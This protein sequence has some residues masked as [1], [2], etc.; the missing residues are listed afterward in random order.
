MTYPVAEKIFERCL[1]SPL[2]PNQEIEVR[3]LLK[4]M[5]DAGWPVEEPTSAALISIVGFFYARAP[6]PIDAAL[7]TE[8]ISRELQESTAII[9]KENIKPVIHL[10]FLETFKNIFLEAMTRAISRTALVLTG[11]LL[12][13]TAYGTHLVDVRYLQNQQVTNVGIN[14][15]S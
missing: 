6:K 14:S 8:Q 3:E 5:N 9:L 1:G 2:N 15:K 4:A 7:A 12:A 13:L 11:V 10:D